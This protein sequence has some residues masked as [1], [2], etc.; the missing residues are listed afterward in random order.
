MRPLHE[1]GGRAGIVLSGSP[2]FNGAAGSGPS[3]IRRWLLES[4]LVEAI[5]ALPTHMFFNTGIATCVWIL[6]NTKRDERRGTVQLIDATSNWTKMG[7]NLGAKSRVIDADA[8]DRILELYDAFDEADPDPDYSKVFATTDFGYW[9]ITDERPL[10]G[11]D[12]E[13]VVDRKGNPKPDLKKRD[14]ENVPFT[15]R[16]PAAVVEPVET[17]PVETQGVSA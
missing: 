8:R 10:L 3:E 6:D 12:G 1:G 16:P 15:Y 4:D 11:E 5:V 13:P 14:T 17:Q 2:V 9:T 7:K